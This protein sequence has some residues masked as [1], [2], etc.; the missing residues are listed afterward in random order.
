MRYLLLLLLTLFSLPTLAAPARKSPPHGFVYVVTTNG[1]AYGF[2]IKPSGALTRLA[3][4]PQLIWPFIPK[5]PLVEDG[6]Q[7][8]AVD[9]A[10][11]LL[12]ATR[13]RASGDIPHAEY[14]VTG[15]FQV[16]RVASDGHLTPIYAKPQSIFAA[17]G[18]ITIDPQ[19]RFVWVSGENGKVWIFRRGRGGTLKPAGQTSVG[20][21]FRNFLMTAEDDYGHM[22]VS[23]DGK[24]VYASQNSGFVDHHEYGIVL[25]R[26]LPNGHLEER[27]A[28]YEN[29]TANLGSFATSGKFI[30]IS[31]SYFNEKCSDRK[32]GISAF[33]V[34]GYRLKSER[35]V[36]SSDEAPAL[37]ADPKG[38]FLFA[39]DDKEVKVYTIKRDG[40]LTLRS[41]NPGLEV[42]TVSRD[43][44]FV[45]A[46]AS[47]E[48]Q[49]TTRSALV[50]ARVNDDG[51]LTRLPPVSLPAGIHVSSVLV[52]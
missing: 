30:Y 35:M 6:G 27:D 42:E 4:P 19:G 20:A 12:Y 2:R 26:V 17:L 36:V 29:I 46:L 28:T 38:R 37:L 32:I 49:G 18:E 39:S 21:T 11:T 1:L 50:S 22:S 44:R 41:R 5:P 31:S 16:Y 10:H 34:E 8:V 7:S 23:P 3:I 51:T 43:G 14:G 9:P 47:T 13:Y 40:T 48:E 25:Y 15:A 52:F 45:Y 24:T 33:S